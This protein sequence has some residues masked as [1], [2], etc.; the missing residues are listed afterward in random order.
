[1][2]ATGLPPL[3]QRAKHIDVTLVHRDQQAVVIDVLNT[4]ATCGSVNVSRSHN[5]TGLP[6]VRTP[7]AVMGIPDFLSLI[8]VLVHLP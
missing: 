1:M 3:V 7:S 2:P 6:S 5:G 4:R 8:Y